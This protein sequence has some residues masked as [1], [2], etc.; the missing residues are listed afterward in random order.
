[1][2]ETVIKEGSQPSPPASAFKCTYHSYPLHT[3]T[4]IHCIPKEKKRIP[5]NNGVRGEKKQ[6]QEEQ[7]G[8]LNALSTINL[9][10][11]NCNAKLETVWRSIL[12]MGLLEKLCHLE[13]L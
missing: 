5:S 8:D 12:G 9:R 7:C 13:L 3:Y 1:M 6:R 4:H 11:L 10:H 2:R